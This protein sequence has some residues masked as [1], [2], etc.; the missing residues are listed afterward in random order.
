[1]H[2]SYILTKIEYQ[3]NNFK[4]KIYSYIFNN[5]HGRREV[6]QV[7][8]FFIYMYLKREVNKNSLLNFGPITTMKLKTSN[9]IKL[10]IRAPPSKMREPYS[11]FKQ[12]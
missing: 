1:M 2:K 4:L 7:L 10:I 8:Y 12:N 11:N 9:A 3:I 6:I 5:G